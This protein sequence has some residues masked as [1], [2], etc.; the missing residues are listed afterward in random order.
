MRYMKYLKYYLSFVLAAVLLSC[1]E[2]DKLTVTIQDTVERGAVLRTVSLT[3]GSWNVTDDT[4]TFDIEWEFQDIEDGGL[5]EEVR[6]FADL[7]DNTDDSTTDTDETQVAT[8]PASEFSPG[9]NGLPRTT[10]QL[11]LGE[12]AAALGIALGDY[13]C[14]DEFN[15]RIELELT[16]G[17]VITNTDLTGTVAGGSFFSSPLNY[18]VPLILLLSSDELFTGQYQLT[19]TSNGSFGVADW[20]D[21]VYT[22]EAIDNVTRVIRGVPPYPAFGA[23]PGVDIQFAFVC[24]QIIYGA[25]QGTGVGCG[26]SIEHSSAETNTTFDIQNPDDSDFSINF[27]SNSADGGCGTTPSQAS[28]RLTK[29]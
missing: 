28:F 23:F 1:S 2:D 6:V 14:G 19:T 5:L 27:T 29:I 18:R 26:G 17:R 22:V 12:V 8:I 13:N 10:Y 21:G 16:D 11:T 20:L 25:S 15:L 24:D 9:V 7:V 4:E 3:G